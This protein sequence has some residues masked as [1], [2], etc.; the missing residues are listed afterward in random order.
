M[1]V[2]I[3]MS[4]TASRLAQPLLH[5]SSTPSVVTVAGICNSVGG[6]VFLTCHRGAGGEYRSVSRLGLLTGNRWMLR[7]R[8]Q[9]VPDVMECAN[10]SRGV[11]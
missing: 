3:A 1:G 7:L 5:R 8:D 9:I 10:C 2:Q 6:S 11:H 4:Q